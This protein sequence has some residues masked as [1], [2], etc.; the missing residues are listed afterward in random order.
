MTKIISTNPGKNY[1]VVGEVLVSTEKEV[2]G[3]VQKAN[4][5]KERW[6]E[7]GL[8]RRVELLRN[9]VNE[10]KKNRDELALLATREMG[11][12]IVHAKLDVDDATRYFT[13][14]LDN[15]SRYISPEITYEDDNTTHTVFYEPIGTA[16]VITPWNYPASNF[17]WGCGQNLIVGNTVVFKHSEECPLFGKKLEEIISSCGLPDGVFNE[18][19]GD[20]KVGDS[21]VHQDI[22]FISFT[23]STKV[24]KYLYKVAAE[25]FIKAVME[26]GGSAP[27]IVFEDAELDKVLETLYSNRFFN[28]GQSCDAMKR[29]VIHENRFDQVVQALKKLLASKRVGN[30]QDESTDIG[31]LV[32]KRQLELLE[33]QVTD[34]IEKGAQIVTGG[35][36][37][38]KLKGAYYEPTI[39]TNV[40]RAMKVWR[41]E[42]FG[43]VLPVIP[44][45][46]EDEALELAND[47][48]YGLGAYIFSKDKI[49]ASRI[50]SQINTG[51][52]SVNNAS[53]LQPCSPFGGYNDGYPVN[54][55]SS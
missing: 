53:Y 35:K 23:G 19:Y 1:E 46:T 4:S 5:A 22:D 30:P 17:V 29:L 28:C 13:W 16:A 52:V 12:P 20:G 26:M 33:T 45:K 44:F 37:P 24:G 14:Y 54:C 7:L 34:A 31:P 36:R 8:K 9:L 10:L 38:E 49:R 18:V 3:K 11:M 40:N 6:K 42:V 27:G 39:L 32:A 47:T 55:K 21:L 48:K 43:P 51:M 25:K 50:A 15:A 41:E 2:R